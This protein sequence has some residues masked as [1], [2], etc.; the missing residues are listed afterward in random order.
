MQITDQPNKFDTNQ[1][2]TMLEHVFQTIIILVIGVICLIIHNAPAR[3]QIYTEFDPHPGWENLQ[4]DD[5][6]FA[7]QSYGSAGY[8]CGGIPANNFYF[9]GKQQKIYKGHVAAEIALQK[10]ISQASAL[11][12]AEDQ[13]SRA[14]LAGEFNPHYEDLRMA[15]FGIGFPYYVHT[16]YNKKVNIDYWNIL[17]NGEKE[18]VTEFIDNL[19]ETDKKNNMLNENDITIGLIAPISIFRNMVWGRKFGDLY[20]ESSVNTIIKGSS[21]TLIGLDVAYLYLWT[22]AA[23]ELSDKYGLVLNDHPSYQ[24]AFEAQ[25]RRPKLQQQFQKRV[26]NT[27]KYQSIVTFFGRGDLMN[28][29]HPLNHRLNY[30]SLRQNR[31][32]PALRN[33]LWS[34]LVAPGEATQM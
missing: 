11:G 25:V 32:L 17:S 3:S 23:G 19:V 30:E 28:E 8:C 7:P 2:I 15:L 9:D 14:I 26:E 6:I 12:I 18:I 24:A 21:R 1:I 13:V 4:I 5:R 31:Y 33:K 22:V 10:I 34:A 27:K 29:E 20:L 16:G